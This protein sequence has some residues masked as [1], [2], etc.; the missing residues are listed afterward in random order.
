MVEQAQQKEFPNASPLKEQKGLAQRML[1]DPPFAHL[2]ERQ[3]QF[4]LATIGVGH[5]QPKIELHLTVDVADLVLV[6]SYARIELGQ[7]T[8]NHFGRATHNERECGDAAIG[9]RCDVR[10]VLCGPTRMD[11][12]LSTKQQSIVNL[13]TNQHIRTRT[14]LVQRSNVQRRVAIVVAT[15][16]IDASNQ[17]QFGTLVA[18]GLLHDRRMQ[19]RPAVLVH[20]IHV[21]LVL[22]QQLHRFGALRQARQVQRRLLREIA[23]VHDSSILEQLFGTLGIIVLGGDVQRSHAGAPELRPHIGAVLQQ[24]LQTFEVAQSGGCVQWRLRVDLRNDS[25]QRGWVFKI[26]LSMLIC[27]K[28]VEYSDWRHFAAMLPR[29][30]KPVSLPPHAEP[31]AFRGPHSR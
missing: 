3:Q 31:I 20:R 13:L 6:D 19:C 25:E 4:G 17:Q 29:T 21:R 28:P 9:A 24:Q 22:Q 8:W 30:S 27:H 14:Q 18:L 10:S 5:Q 15:I 12:G 7:E 26:F 16:H 23:R 11:N 1:E 2:D